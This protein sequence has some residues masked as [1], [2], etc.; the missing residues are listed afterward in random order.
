[1]LLPSTTAHF[2]RRVPLA[3]SVDY[4]FIRQLPLRPLTTVSSVEY[5]FIRRL[6]LRASTTTS[7]VDYRFIRRQLLRPSTAA[8]F[9]YRL[10]LA[11][12]IDRSL[13]PSTTTLSVD[14]H[15]VNHL[16]LGPST[17]VSSVY[18]RSVQLPFRSSTTASSTDYRSLLPSTIARFF[19]RLLLASSVDYRFIRRVPLVLVAAVV[20]QGFAVELPLCRAEASDVSRC[21]HCIS[22]WLLG[23]S[24]WPYALLLDI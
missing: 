24:L 10:P 18:Y 11:S 15:F 1:M 3:S 21:I 12:S 19:H 14:Y 16:P 5:R 6:M 22:H 20:A 7:S 23:G 8:R 17:T 13:L 9:F 2:F 4:R